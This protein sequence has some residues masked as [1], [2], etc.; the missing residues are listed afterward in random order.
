[1]YCDDHSC[2]EKQMLLDIANNILDDI[3]RGI[4]VSDV[5]KNLLRYI[6]VNSKKEI[7]I[8]RTNIGIKLNRAIINEMARRGDKT[9]IEI[10]TQNKFTHLPNKNGYIYE[11]AHLYIPGTYKYDRDNKILLDIIKEGKLKNNNSDVLEIYHVSKTEWSEEQIHIDF[12]IDT[13][14]SGETLSCENI[15]VTRLDVI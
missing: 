8:N 5:R 4:S 15:F 1:M 14:K 6:Y 9:A 12:D 7:I 10:V 3:E 2:V 11:Y 13:G